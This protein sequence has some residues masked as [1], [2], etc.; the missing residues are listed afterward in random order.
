MGYRDTYR[1]PGT[2]KLIELRVGV[3]PVMYGWGATVHYLQG[4]S[5]TCK[6]VVDVASMWEVG[7]GY[8]ALSRLVS[9]DIV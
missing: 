1:T 6:L 2:C 4:K 9:F 3:V 5:V 7:M 8:V